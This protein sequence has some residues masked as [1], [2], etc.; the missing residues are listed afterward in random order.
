MGFIFGGNTG[1]SYEDIQAKRKIAEQLLQQNASTPRNVGEGLSAIGRALAYRNITK[2]A[3][4]ADATN[5]AAFDQQYSGLFAGSS[6][7]SAPS[8]APVDPNSPEG[9]G[10]AT[11]VALGKAPDFAK[12]ESTYGLPS[13]YLSRTAQLE[14]GGNPNA[15]NPNSSAGGMFQ[16]IDSTAKQYGL[17]DK[18]DP[19]ASA[20][21]A[22]RLA[23]D[24]KAYLTKA[25]GREPSAGELYLAHQQGPAGA[26]KLIL[27]QGAPAA[28]LVGNDAVALNGGS[29]GMTGGDFAQKWLAKFGGEQPQ[30]GSGMSIQA[31]AEV[32]GSPY[33]TP[34]QKAVAAAL[35]Q[36]QMDAADP[37]KALDLEKKRLELDAMKNPKADPGYRVLTP[38]EA[39]QMNLPQGAYQMGPDGKISQIGGGGTSVTVNNGSD[40]GTIPQGFE[41]FTDPKTGARSMRAIPGGPEDKSAADATKA[42][43]KETLT[44]VVVNAAARARSAAGERALGGFGQGAVAAINP[45]SDSAEV[46]RQVDVL[47]SNATIESLNAMRA[48][49]PTGGALGAVSDSENKML[50]AKAGALDPSSPNFA[51][52]LDDYELTLLK[53][54]HGAEAGERIFK[55]TRGDKPQIKPPATD[56]ALPDGVTQEEWDAMTPEDRALWQN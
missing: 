11:M 42:S 49:S 31:L 24:N 45:Y 32:A 37:E 8:F 10:D 15:Q 16:F 44:D 33:A 17:T 29:G 1:Q 36:Q 51:R 23:A 38:D 27:N 5:K 14:S 39:A 46:Q 34:G 19:I 40:V 48:A 35:L 47:K 43:N 30:S 26:A 6:G 12:L 22:A 50:A 41:L 9:I 52:D 56:A 13:G 28:S 18:T 3:D 7:G 54:V 2:K 21:A 20:D 4:A 55:E 25:L 53:T